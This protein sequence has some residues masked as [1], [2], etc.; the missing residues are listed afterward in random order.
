MD[1]YGYFASNVVELQEDDLLDIR[2][3]P[4]AEVLE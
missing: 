2:D 4:R 1:E 3:I